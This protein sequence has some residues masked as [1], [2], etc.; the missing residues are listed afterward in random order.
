MFGSTALHMAARKGDVAVTRVLF[1]ANADPVLRNKLGL[2]APDLARHNLGAI[3]EVLEAE[4]S[5]KV[6]S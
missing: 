2:T 4:F 5:E 1:E 6:A 3:P